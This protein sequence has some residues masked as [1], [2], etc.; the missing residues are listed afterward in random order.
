MG[1]QGELD[2]IWEVPDELWEE[3]E[4]VIREIDP[5]KETG[6]PRV[7]ARRAFDGIIY[8]LRTSC[9]WNHL[10]E[11][12]GSD[13]SV[14]RTFQRW[15]EKGVFQEV[16]ALLVERCDDLGAVEWKWQAADGAMGKARSG[17]T[18][19]ARTRRTERKLAAR[20]ASSSTVTA[21]R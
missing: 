20:R 9:Q 12:F 17:G 6:R 13:S 8:R 18:S 15:V 19:S 5:P 1:K 3:I 10:P 21:G 16:W 7:D 2:T 14:H 11:N 4:Q